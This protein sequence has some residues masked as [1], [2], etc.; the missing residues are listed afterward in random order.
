MRTRGK[1]GG[2]RKKG[3]ARESSKYVTSNDQIMI[4]CSKVCVKCNNKNKVG[5]TR[6]LQGNGGPTEYGS[7]SIRQII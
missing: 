2:G 7:I 3:V 1:D 4:D 6:S 5:G